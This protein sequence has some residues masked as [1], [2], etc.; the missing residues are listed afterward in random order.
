[1]PDLVL[2]DSGGSNLGSVQAALERL[3][4][5]APVSGDPARIRAASHVI[6]PGVG[7]AA[8]AMARLRE[9]GLVEVIQQ[10]KQPV[11][12]VCVGMQIL[13]EHSEEGDT[14]CLGLFPGVIRR[15]KPAPGIRIPHM[16]WNQ[17]RALGSHPLTQGLDQQ[18]A[19]FVHSFAAA[20]TESTMLSVDHGQSFAALVVRG[21]YHGAQ[22]HP[23]RSAAAGAQLL[24]NF[25]GLEG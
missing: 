22:F 10:L 23:E 11:L 6:L 21:N 9:Q 3:G 15:L 4:V 12:G 13:F 2:V 8:V 16:G 17:L 20:V 14:P 24:E 5:A 18:H 7:A 1:M 25:L 19:Y